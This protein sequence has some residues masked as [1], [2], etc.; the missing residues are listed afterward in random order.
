MVVISAP[1]EVV[2][3]TLKFRTL[4]IAPLNI[5]SPLMPRSY[6]AALT[7]VS[8]EL[9]VTVEAVKV[10]EALICTGPVKLSEALPLPVKLPSK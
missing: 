3:E 10:R 6:A 9:N 5:A 4:V 7:V 1:I 2:P 8:V